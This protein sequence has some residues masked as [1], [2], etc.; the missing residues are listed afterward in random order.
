MIDTDFL[1][2]LTEIPSVGTACQPII[3]LL[4]SRIGT[5]YPHRW[6]SDG[7]CLFQKRGATPNDLKVLYVAHLDEIGGCVYGKYSTGEGCI[8]RTWGNVPS[9]FANATLQ[10]FDYLAESANA[11]FPVTGRV[12]N[13]DG[14]DRMVLNGDGIR[15]YRTVFTFQQE[16]TFQGDT[17]SGK[18]LDPRVTLYSVMEAAL[19][20]NSPEVGLLCV[21]AEE[22][23][24]DVARK[25]VIYLQKTAPNLQLIINADVPWIENIGD[26]RLDLPAIRV[27]EGRNFIDPM[28]G[29]HAADVMERKG[30]EF[31]L[32]AARSGSQTLLFTPLAP[33][34]SI[35]LPSD[36]IH[37]PCY[38]MSLKG[39]QR[40][41]TLLTALAEASLQNELIPTARNTK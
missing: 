9:I 29:I 40:C 32:S 22:C 37:Q 38:K 33:T 14:E 10:A 3:N 41:V 8:T 36:G 6:V 15:P 21:M 23:A 20:M 25:A 27:F 12:E 16:T 1:K 26:G 28:V 13:V 24:M 18:A 19:A 34:L 35:A 30:V 39:T 31:H 11:T 2:A 5:T 4:H 17:I 7:Y